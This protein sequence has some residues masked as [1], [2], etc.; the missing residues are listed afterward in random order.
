MH[1]DFSDDAWEDYTYWIVQDKKTL[2]NCISPAT[3]TKDLRGTKW[4]EGAIAFLW[5]KSNDMQQAGTQTAI[6][7]SGCRDGH[8]FYAT[9]ENLWKIATLFTVR[10]IIQHTETEVG[11]PA[12]FESVRHPPQKSGIVLKLTT[13]YER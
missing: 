4:A 3:A 5:C 6:F 10:R 12:R 8:G 1:K 9:E 13:H 7:S 11:S 2:K